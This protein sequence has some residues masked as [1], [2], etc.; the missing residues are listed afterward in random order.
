MITGEIVT[1]EHGYTAT[2]MVGDID[3][4][5]GFDLTALTAEGEHHLLLCS[6]SVQCFSILSNHFI[7]DLDIAFRGT[8]V[9]AISQQAQELWP[10]MT[11]PLSDR[12]DDGAVLTSE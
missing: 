6:L 8:P 3:E 2:A 11:L 9:F 10:T 12:G 5:D 1:D 7:T 4:S